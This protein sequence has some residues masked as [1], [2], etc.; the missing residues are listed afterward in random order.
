MFKFLIAFSFTI[1]LLELSYV[2]GFF[3]LIN[4]LSC[5]NNCCCWEIKIS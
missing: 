3:I 2:D 5:E 4:C 1:K